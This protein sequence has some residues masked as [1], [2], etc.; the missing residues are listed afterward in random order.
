[1][2]FITKAY[3]WVVWSS[4]NAEKYSATLKALLSGGAAV[5][6][7]SLVHLNLPVEDVNSLLDVLVTIA[8]TSATILTAV[9]TAVGL[10]RKIVHTLT[11][12]NDLLNKYY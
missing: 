3:D 9:F 1:M 6:L 10:I 11:G 7:L 2:E 8:Q 5:F 4:A 12:N